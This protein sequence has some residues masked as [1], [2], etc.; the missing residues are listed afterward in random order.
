MSTSTAL[1]ESTHGASL[2][3]SQ[4]HHHYASPRAS[5]SKPTSSSSS[6]LRAVHTLRPRGG[7][8]PNQLPS[9]QRH[10]SSDSKE[11]EDRSTSAGTSS[12]SERTIMSS[13]K[14]SSPPLKRSIDAEHTSAP[15]S[16]AEETTPAED[17]GSRK[18]VKLETETTARSPSS[19]RLRTFSDPDEARLRGREDDGTDRNYTWQ[20]SHAAAPPSLMSITSLSSPARNAAAATKASRTGP[21]TREEL[22]QAYALSSPPSLPARLHRGEPGSRLPGIAS[23]SA[24]P[25]SPPPQV[26]RVNAP[27]SFVSAANSSNSA[28]LYGGGVAGSSTAGS[29]RL[30]YAPH[31]A[32]PPAY[33]PQSPR[34][35]QSLLPASTHSHHPPTLFGMQQGG[36][37]HPTLSTGSPILVHQATLTCPKIHPSLN[38][39]PGSGTG[40][41]NKQQPSF[42][43]KLYSMLEDDSISNMISWGETGDTFSV[44]NPSEFSRLVLPTWFKHANWQSFVRQLNMYGFHKVNHT[45]SG[46]P[47]EEVQIWEFKHGSF[48]RGQ[49]HLLQDIKRKSSRHKSTGS[50]SQSFSGSLHSFDFDGRMRSRSSTPPD[51]YT[52]DMAMHGSMQAD[53]ASHEVRARLGPASE[54]DY[55]DAVPARVRSLTDAAMRPPPRSAGQS[56]HEPGVPRHGFPTHAAG[57]PPRPFGG[58]SSVATGPTGPSHG[59]SSSLSTAQIQ[60][61]DSSDTARPGLI[62]QLSDRIDQVIHHSNFLEQQV[63]VLSDQVTAESSAR[64]HSVNILGRLLD[65]CA[66]TPAEDTSPAAA[67]QTR[68]QMLEACHAELTQLSSLPPR[69]WSHSPETAMSWQEPASAPFHRPSSMQQSHVSH[70]SD[71]NIRMTHVQHPPSTSPEV[72]RRQPPLSGSG[73]P[74]SSSSRFTA[75][76]AAAAPPNPSSHSSYTFPRRG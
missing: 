1:R 36:A 34:S 54:A 59:R 30:P 21:E 13:S 27:R 2:F 45:F 16:G 46:G 32:A 29:A 25:T 23:L 6:S 76:A 31:G 73:P 26:S 74:P 55:R 63:R 70:R 48:R 61:D 62:Q 20:P 12:P 33:A 75:A 10:P 17:G 71:S 68:R 67:E 40:P 14:L 41:G 5:P 44:S 53:L 66:Y 7:D 35:G 19:R 24:R 51:A 38:G 72:S 37:N 57:F 65:I 52:S 49:V 9:V 56:G 18:A 4:P 22:S 11:S 69:E 39:L 47:N 64:L 50:Q 28:G 8:H 60:H 58:P 3:A 43:A 15:P 42:V